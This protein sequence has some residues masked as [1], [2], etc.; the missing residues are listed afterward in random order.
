VPDV[1]PSPA[2]SQRPSEPGRV[3]GR[4]VGVLAVDGAD[5]GVV[6]TLGAALGPE[7]VV[8]RVVADHG[9]TVTGAG[10]A[11]AAVDRTIAT[12]RSIEYDA[13]VVAPGVAGTALA[14][15][16]RTAGLLQEAFRHGKALAAVGDGT[17]VLAAAGVA[18]DAPGVLT[19]DAAVLAAP[20]RDA[21]GRHRS[22]ERLAALA[23][24]EDAPA[25]TPTH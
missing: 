11:T 12:T 13:V 20:L 23:G 7:K 18:T 14:R 1:A 16:P 24:V 15:D 21:L 19:G 5:L 22:W 2:L 9:G 25:P 17:D 3:D 8:V 10:G 4:V 6:T